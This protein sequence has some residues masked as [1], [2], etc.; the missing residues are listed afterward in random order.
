MSFLNVE[1]KARCAD[2]EKAEFVLMQE[3]A[4]FIGLDHQVDTYFNI[5]E[6][7]MKLREGNI[8]HSLIFYKRENQEG[9]KTS[10]VNLYQPPRDPALKSLLENSMGVLVVVDKHRK[11]FFIDNVKFHIDQ[12][13]KLGSFIEI[14]AIDTDGSIGMEKLQKQCKQ[15]MQLLNIKTEELIAVSYSD[16]LLKEKNLYE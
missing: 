8:E 5:P 10:E 2:P 4:V 7:R 11:I 13:E 14:E 12:V 15:F 9:P 16:M 1:I 6:G 3:Q